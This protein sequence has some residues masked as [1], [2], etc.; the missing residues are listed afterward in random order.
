MIMMPADAHDAGWLGVFWQ[1]TPQLLLMMLASWVSLTKDAPADAHDAGRLG[2][3][4]QRTPQLMLMMLAGLGFSG[5]GRP[6]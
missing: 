6:G 1:R 2:V 3:L 5:K 4:W